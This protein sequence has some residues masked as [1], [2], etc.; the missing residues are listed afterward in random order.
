MCRWQVYDKETGVTS[1]ETK[2]QQLADEL[3]PEEAA[4]LSAQAATNPDDLAPSLRAK[5]QQHAESL[6]P[7]E[8]AELQALEDSV[9][10]EVEGHMIN[11]KKSSQHGLDLS[12][13][14]SPANPG[15]HDAIKPPT[16]V[17]PWL[18]AVRIH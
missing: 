1:L 8:W 6:T 13:L 7:D 12:S 11:V 2:L 5:L 18:S 17:A 9:D 14:R 3:T 15:P 4:L 10:D 16:F